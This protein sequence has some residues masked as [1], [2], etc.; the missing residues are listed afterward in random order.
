MLGVEYL[1]YKAKNGSILISSKIA[2][3]FV[4]DITFQKNAWQQATKE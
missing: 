1:S 2:N 4:P 3:P